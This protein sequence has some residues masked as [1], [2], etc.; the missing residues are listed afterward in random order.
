MLPQQRNKQ[1]AWL[2][3]IHYNVR[4]VWSKLTL[5]FLSLMSRRVSCLNSSSRQIG[6][7]QQVS[8]SSSCLLRRCLGDD[9]PEESSLLHHATRVV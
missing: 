1:D 2:T 3:R 8:G 9:R 5:G 6:F 4:L 7:L